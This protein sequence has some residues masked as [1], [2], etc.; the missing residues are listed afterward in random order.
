MSFRIPRTVWYDCNDTQLIASTG[1]V[2]G[3][4]TPVDIRDQEIVLRLHTFSTWPAKWDLSGIASWKADIGTYGADSLVQVGNACFNLHDDWSARKPSEG[5][6]CFH[7]S[8]DSAA[9]KADMGTSSNKQ[10]VCIITGTDSG[11]LS[12]PLIEIPVVVYGIVNPDTGDSSSSESSESSMKSSQSESSSS[13]GSSASSLSTDD[14][15]GGSS[16]SSS[17]QTV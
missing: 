8:L 5:R 17:S 3:A 10:Y 15:S 2:T 12:S 13:Q 9:L 6:I 4:V 16:L 11:G 7:A 14:S 1:T